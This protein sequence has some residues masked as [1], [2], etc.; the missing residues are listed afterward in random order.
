MLDMG[1]VGWLVVGFLA[2]SL[3]GLVVRRG[4]PRG[5]LATTLIGILG[6]LLGGF[7]AR[8]LRLGDTEGFTGAVVVAFLGAVLV[9]LL[10]DA[11]AGPPRRY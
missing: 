7:L 3:S 9:R 6:G 4:S 5:C 11:M 8:E 2:G 1:L 10:L